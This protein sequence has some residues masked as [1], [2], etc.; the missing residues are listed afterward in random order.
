MNRVFEADMCTPAS[1]ELDRGEESKPRS[2]EGDSARERTFLRLRRVFCRRWYESG[3]SFNPCK[4]A[5]NSTSLQ[6]LILMPRRAARANR[7]PVLQVPQTTIL[8]PQMTRTTKPTISLPAVEAHLPGKTS[9][10]KIFLNLN[11]LL[12]NVFS[13]SESGSGS[14]SDSGSDEEPQA[15][16]PRKTKRSKE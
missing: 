4:P 12:I 16:P 7:N 10:S 3:L 2:S 11:V 15:S 6:T 1:H 5:F 9:H 8:I 13:D 14:S